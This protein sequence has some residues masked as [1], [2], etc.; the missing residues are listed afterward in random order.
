MRPGGL[1]GA[2]VYHARRR[3]RDARDRPAHVAE[4]PSPMS[5]SPARDTYDLVIVGGGVFGLG[6]ALE[7]SR[8]G[9]TVALVERGPIPNPVAASYGPSRKIRSTYTEPHYAMLAREAMA[10]WREIEREVGQELYIPAGNFAY[11][12]RDEQ[13]YLDELEAVSREIGAPVVV[14]DEAQARARFPQ[15]RLARRALLETDA[16]FL[17]ASACVA[18]LR[19][20]AERAGA[21]ILPER[22]VAAIDAAGDAVVVRTAD[23]GALRGARAVVALGGWSKRLLPELE[24]TLTQTQQGIMYVSD[25]PAPFHHPEMPAFSW[26]DENFYGFPVWG[27]DAFKVAHHTYGRPVA[28]PDFDRATTPVGFLDGARAFLRDHLGLDPDRLP[29][30]AESC[31]YNLS[32]S[33]DFLL[34]VHPREPRLFVATG[35]SGHGFKFGSVI[36]SVVLERLEGAPA[37]RWHPMFSWERVRGAAALTRLR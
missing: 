12:I 37:R 36:G 33:S 21:T 6:T 31:M 23:G 24:A 28:T 29:T 11:T 13:P 3:R 15:F 22:E 32:P 5:P 16:G 20:L 8:R 7:A 34:D 25:A 1:H 14:L 2:A 27:A 19:A 26:S 30:R 4:E 18:A 35:G 17:R 10:A 9:L